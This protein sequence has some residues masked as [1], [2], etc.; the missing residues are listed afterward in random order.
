LISNAT[1]I[2]A[3]RGQ[4]HL[5]ELAEMGFNLLCRLSVLAKNRA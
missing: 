5:P 2:I 1:S 4:E 3:M